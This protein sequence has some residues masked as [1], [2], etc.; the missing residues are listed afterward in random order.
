M[1]KGPLSRAEQAAEQLKQWLS[2]GSLGQELPG[3]ETLAVECGVS[4]VTMR[5]ALRILERDGFISNLGPGRG[6]TVQMSSQQRA[7]GRSLQVAMLSSSGRESIDL[8]YRKLLDLFES[9]LFSMGHRFFI[10]PMTQQDLGYDTSR[11]IKRVEKEKVDLWVVDSAQAEL[12]RWFASRPQPVFA[13]G[14]QFLDVPGIAATGSF[15]VPVTMDTVRRLCQLGHR[16][17][18]CLKAGSLRKNLPFRRTLFSTLEEAGIKASNYNLPDWEETAEGLHQLLDSL[19]QVSP[20]TA[21][22]VASPV[23]MQGV[24]SFLALRGLKTPDDVSLVCERYDPGL[25]W[26]RPKITHF[27]HDDDGALRIL[28]RWMKG[29]IDSKPYTKQTLLPVKVVEGGTVGPAPSHA[30]LRK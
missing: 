27:Q 29:V 28:R 7:K 26:C 13:C 1:R 11:I 23:W 4:P 24:L 15:A 19:F 17:I 5:Q 22:I 16:R 12:L 9:E 3:V 14:G 6:R 25:A 8:G 18:V 21:L 20:P 30:L 2:D 10:L